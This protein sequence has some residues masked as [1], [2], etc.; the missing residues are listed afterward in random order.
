MTLLKRFEPSSKGMPSPLR[1]SGNGPDRK[2]LLAI[3][4]FPSASPSGLSTSN[5]DNRR[6]K[7]QTLWQFQDHYRNAPTWCSRAPE[8]LRGVDQTH[9]PRKVADGKLPS[10]LFQTREFSGPR[11]SQALPDPSDTR[12]DEHGL[13]VK[14]QKTNEIA[15]NALKIE[16]YMDDHSA[17]YRFKGDVDETFEY[18]RI[19]VASRQT[20]RFDLEGI[21]S[22]NSCGV[23]EWSNLMKQ[24][25]SGVELVL[26]KCSVA[27]V[28]QFNIVPQTMGRA[29]IQSFFAPYYCPSCDE[30]TSVLLD[31]EKHRESLAKKQ[32]PE[33]CHHCGT[34][35]EFD[36]LEDCYFHQIDR[37]FAQKAS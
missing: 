10:H 29:F 13:G 1:Q 36:A 33:V 2:A 28:D 22:I 21:A 6:P 9:L 5:V 35:L 34:A 15:F 12:N 7:K 19:P 32:A 24:F 16:I 26:E 27:I 30:E 20:I 17:L 14:M 31:T 11:K 3:W 23:R 25:S 4:P 18:K 37:F 8:G